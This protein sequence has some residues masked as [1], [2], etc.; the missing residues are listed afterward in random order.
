MLDTKII[1]QRNAL[2]KGFDNELYAMF[3]VSAK[4]IAQNDKVRKNLN[5]ALV[6][7]RSGSMAG[8]PLEEAKKSAV[9][10][11]N[12]MQSSDRI[13][14]IQYD[15]IAEVVVPST[16]CIDKENIIRSIMRIQ[17]GGM[18]NLFQ[19]WE[20]GSIEVEKNKTKQT[21]N[22]ILLLSDGN[23]NV[24]LT[25]I[26]KIASKCAQLIEK[27]ITTST[28]GLGLDF[29]EELMIE[30]ANSGHG[31]GYYGQ[32]AEDLYD[33]FKEE[34]SLLL[35]TIATELL[36]KV[37]C[38]N[39]ITLKVMNNLKNKSGKWL[40][41]DIA[42]SGEGWV[43]LKLNIAKE[44]IKDKSIEVLRCSLSYKKKNGLIEKTDPIKLILE[45][46]PQNAFS[47][48]AEDEKVK[49]RISEIL[50]ARYQREA[51]DAAQIGDWDRVDQ[52]VTEAKQAAEGDEWISKAIASLEK[53]SR[54]RDR[55]T[56]SKEALYSAEYMEKRLVS[57][58]EN[59]LWD[60]S[61]EEEKLPFLRK[62]LQRGKRW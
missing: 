51:R 5:L 8:Q 40:M 48:V 7:D 32:C 57:N 15:N 20:L 52:I 28:Y 61:I 13:A 25:G 55:E 24:G 39:F 19:G 17:S 46:L 3:Q 59:S 22:K 18:T 38:P 62:K 23:A 54:M 29:N 37:K 58:N 49:S 44:K 12:Q 11:V 26:H 53:Y 35:N 6:I 21:L 30:M 36:L 9:M 47:A 2:L 50:V 41:P 4:D 10:M 27:G 34:F 42:A 14:I 1:P 43:L 45:P 56:F 60:A 33:P 31:R 16:K